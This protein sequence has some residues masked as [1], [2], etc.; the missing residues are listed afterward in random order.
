MFSVPGAVN[1]PNPSS[2]L[3]HDLSET[4]EAF[5]ASQSHSLLSFVSQE[6]SEPSQC[7]LNDIRFP[8]YHCPQMTAEL[9]MPLLVTF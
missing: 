7:P 3:T 6:L 5:V 1:L 9:P 4:R 8:E 2:H